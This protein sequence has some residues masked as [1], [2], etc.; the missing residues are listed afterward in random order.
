MLSQQFIYLATTAGIIWTIMTVVFA[1]SVF[2]KDNSI[3]DIFYG[4]V[5]VSVA[6][7]LPTIFQELQPVQFLLTFLITIWGVRLATRIFLKNRGK[8]ED[9]RYNRWRVEWGKRG[10]QYFLIRSYVQI[11]MLQGVVIF[12][13]LLPLVLVGAQGES[14]IVVPHL[15]LIGSVIWIVGFFFEVVSDIQ[16]DSF[17]RKEENHGKV[18]TSGLFRF[19]RRPNYFGESAM[20]WGIGLIAASVLP[21][22]IAWAGYLSPIVITYIVYAVTGP[23]LEDFWKHNKEYQ[24]YRKRTNYFFPWFPKRNKVD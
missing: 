14:E 5:F 24:A 4:L 11:F 12:F 21:P 13:V 18:M 7:L 15:L 6:W 20:W 17:L 2:K 19:S 1:V 22:S 8:P 16:L 3:I 10:N 23:I 9:H